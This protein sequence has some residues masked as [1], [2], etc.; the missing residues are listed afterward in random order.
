MLVL[1]LLVLFMILTDADDL[2]IEDW[3]CTNWWPNSHDNLIS[4]SEF[5]NWS[6]ASIDSVDGD[7][8]TYT[9]YE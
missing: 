9:H 2:L 1:T 8:G 4:I 5:S 6:L 7:E 3:I